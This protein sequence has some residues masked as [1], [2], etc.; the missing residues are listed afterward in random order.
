MM[1]I[2]KIF[3]LF[4]TLIVSCMSENTETSVSFEYKLEVSSVQ[5]SG[6]SQVVLDQID[7]MIVSTFNLSYR[8]EN[9]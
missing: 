6:S 7:S 8:T 1:M 4:T 3:L 9:L 5:Q 2:S